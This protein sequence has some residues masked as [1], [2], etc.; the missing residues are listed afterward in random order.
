MSRNE[1]LD[2][3]PNGKITNDYL[4]RLCKS[5]GG[6]M[7]EKLNEKLYLQHKGVTKI[8]N[9]DKFT[10]VK[11]L[12][13][14]SNAVNKIEGLECLKEL[15]CLYIHQNCIEHIEGIFHC[16]QLH[17]LNI[18]ENFISH[19]PEELG[20]YCTN[21]QTLDLNSNQLRTLDSV[22]ALRY[23]SKLSILDLSKNK[24]FDTIPENMTQEQV[25]EEFLAILKSLTEL[26]LLRLEGN[27]LVRMIPN[28]RKEIISQIPSLNYLDNMPIFEDERRT[29]DAWKRGGVEEEREERKRI[30]Q[31]K[32][33]KERKNFEAFERLVEN[34]RKQAQQT[35]KSIDD[36]E[37]ET[38]V[39]EQVEEFKTPDATALM[40]SSETNQISTNTEKTPVD[41]AVSNG[42]ESLFDIE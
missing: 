22:K 11:V 29:V 9:L 14:E 6:Y 1:D 12:W 38:N 10:G 20:K 31:E 42:E 33:E 19:I 35:E 18:S 7:T 40:T 16:E 37:N 13:L 36:S 8:E 27:P 30:A 32:K 15:A 26:K 39:D 28:Y 24:L 4:R 25:I 34:A 2:R 17:T 23:C 3:L 41:V 5:K 21:L